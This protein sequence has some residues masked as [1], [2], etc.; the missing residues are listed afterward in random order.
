MPKPSLKSIFLVCSS[1]EES[2]R[3]YRTLGFEQ[4]AKKS[5]SQIFHLGSGLELHLHEALTD[6]EEQRYKV[7]NG[8]GSTSLVQSF[9][10]EDVDGLAERLQ[11]RSILAPPQ[12]SPWGTRLLL[13][14]D[15][16]GHRLEFRERN[17]I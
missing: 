17:K 1:L 8:E 4:G 15:P 5:R 2:I 13:I 12:Q 14:Q 6:E 9:E 7:S 11:F 3:F 16:D 10:T